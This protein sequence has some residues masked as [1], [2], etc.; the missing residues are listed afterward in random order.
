V[1]TSRFSWRT[2]DVN[3]L[4]PLG[5]Q[6][7]IISV[8]D[9]CATERTFETNRV[10]RERHADMPT[11]SLTVGNATVKAELPWLEAFYE[12]LFRDLTQL[13]SDEQVS[14]ACKA[15][16][17][18]ALNAQRGHGMRHD[19]HVDSNPLQAL[20]YVTDHPK[21]SGGELVVSNRPDANGV[22]E[23]TRSAASSTRLPGTSSCSTLGASLIT[24][25]RWHASTRSEWWPP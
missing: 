12:G 19:C 5:W 2:W 9:R 13:A 15:S 3:T 18:V 23:W 10:S 24:C 11:T 22:S 4:L 17:R 14:T 8:V 1:S 25:D 20:L 21:G 16:H 7:E 6:A